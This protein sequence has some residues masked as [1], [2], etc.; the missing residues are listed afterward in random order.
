MGDDKPNRLKWNRYDIEGN[1]ISTSLLS[2]RSWLRQFRT[3]RTENN[4]HTLAPKSESKPP[5]WVHLH[6]VH[7]SLNNGHN[8]NY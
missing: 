3:I 8:T 5:K 1:P 4:F 6:I 2:N 7:C